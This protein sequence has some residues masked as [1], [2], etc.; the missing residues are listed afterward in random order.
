MSDSVT[1]LGTL[2]AAAPPPYQRSVPAA[3][4]SESVI[5][6]VTLPP[7]RPGLRR[8]TAASPGDDVG[9]AAY[10]GVATVAGGAA[11]F[12]LCL[13]RVVLMAAAVS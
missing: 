7:I 5:C 13:V 3:A 11:M 8:S 12:L 6:L 4:L 10:H 1:P 9:L 2:P